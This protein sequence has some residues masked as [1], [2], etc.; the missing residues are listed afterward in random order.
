[1]APDAT[2]PQ[3]TFLSQILVTQWQYDVL[4]GSDTGIFTSTI[5]EDNGILCSGHLLKI[6]SSVK[7]SSYKI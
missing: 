7:E 6:Y 3:F 2:T 4:G 1:M 5:A